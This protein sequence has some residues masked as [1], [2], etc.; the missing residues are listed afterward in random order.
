MSQSGGF[1][2]SKMSTVSK[3]LL[4]AGVVYL[5][6]LFL[7]WQS[8]DL[9]F[10]TVTVSGTHGF[11]ILNLLLVIAL[12]AWEVMAI[13]G[14]EIN[15]PKALVSA[16]L[17]GGIV[18]FTVLKILVDNDF[19]AIFAWIGLLLAAAIGY[20]GWMRWQEHQAA[21]GGMSMGGGSGTGGGG[22]SGG[23]GGGGGMPPSPPSD[24]GGPAV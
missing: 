22:D 1:D 8:V 21:G 16:G 19:I 20:G 15:A 9:G 17:A 13:R 24:S 4:G 14:I 3:I 18:V 10:A 12:I 2:M 5:I 23:M 11:G 7:P 6:D